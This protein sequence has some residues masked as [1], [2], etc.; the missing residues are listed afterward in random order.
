METLNG[1]NIEKIEFQNSLI[2][3]ADVQNVEGPLLTLFKS[4]LDKHLYLF[5]W[6]DR[7]NQ[8][9][10][11]IVYACKHNVFRKFIKSKISH[12][13][14]LMSGETLCFLVDIDKNITWHNVQLIRKEHLPKSYFPNKE[15]FFEKSDCPNLQKLE[16]FIKIASGNRVRRRHLLK[17]PLSEI[18]NKK[19]ESPQRNR[20]SELFFKNTLDL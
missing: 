3:I 13:D 6:V 20:K 14:L 17:H 7:D 12:Y 11:W 19:I 5:D 2:R 15:I 4:V 18:P 9:N 10:R 16:D 8:F 1:K